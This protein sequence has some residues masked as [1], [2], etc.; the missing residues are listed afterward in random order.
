MTAYR[1]HSLTATDILVLVECSIRTNFVVVL[2][3]AVPAPFAFRDRKQ[4]RGLDDPAGERTDNPSTSPERRPFDVPR[5][6]RTAPAMLF[7]GDPAAVMTHGIRKK[8]RIGNAV[9]HQGWKVNVDAP[10]DEERR[11]S[12]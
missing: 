11:D 10:L 2:R 1:T 4:S 9:L 12:H 8:S 7:E 5:E 3:N 6:Q